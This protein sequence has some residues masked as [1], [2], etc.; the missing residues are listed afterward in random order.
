M[1]VF[2]F[3]STGNGLSLARKTGGE[4]ISIPQALRSDTKEYKDDAIGFIFPVY[5]GTVPRIMEKF[6]SSKKFEAEY[7][8]AVALYGFFSG[9]AVMNFEKLAAKYNVKLDYTDEIKMVDNYLP[10]FSI[11]KEL[12][13]V[14]SKKI[15]ENTERILQNINTRT[16]SL[17]KLTFVKAAGTFLEKPMLHKTNSGKAAHDFTVNENCVKCG[18]CV[19]VCPAGNVTLSDHVS[20]GDA[21]YS[22]FACV[23]ACPKNAIHVKGERSSKRW[24]NQEVTLKDLMDSN[25]QH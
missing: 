2:Y 1:K 20:F 8:F 4:C 24:R 3:T 14:P 9:A 7:F 12:E 25:N 16:H 10:L 5:D 11:E 22:C 21:C 19:R 17:K 23:H 6:L 18:T 15:E 13:K